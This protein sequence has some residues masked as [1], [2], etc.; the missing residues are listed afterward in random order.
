LV[1]I[2][3]LAGVAII[4]LAG[5]RLAHYGDVIAEKTG[6]GRV[7]I[8][9]LLLAAITSVPEVVTSVSSAVL[10]GLPDLA[11]GTLFGSNLFNLAILA[12]LD[13]TYPVIPI[14]ATISRRQMLLATGGILLIGLAGLS[15][16]IGDGLKAVSLG[17][18]GMPSVLIIILYGFLLRLA[19]KR[20]KAEPGAPQEAPQY[21]DLPINTVWFRFALASAAVIAAGVWLSYTGEEIAKVTG[22]DASFVGSLFLAVSTSMPELVVTFAAVRL[23]AADMAVADILGSNMFNMAIIFIVDLAYVKGSIFADATSVHAI[24]ALAGVLMSLV[25][26]VAIRFHRK[27]KILGVL[28]WYSPFLIVFYLAGFYALFR[29][30]VS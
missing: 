20:E 9:L 22:W 19:F 25:V 13:I 8:G 30:G 23:G 28:S 27:K 24:T 21:A 18:L 2:E 16:F 6:L 4:F 1:W 10:V 14:L 7:W 26:L 17:W 11:V 12:L 5:T 3:F 15:I 29:A